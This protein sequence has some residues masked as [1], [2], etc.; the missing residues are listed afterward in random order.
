MSRF[1]VKV[2]DNSNGGDIEL[3]GDFNYLAGTYPPRKNEYI[4][5]KDVEYKVGNIYHKITSYSSTEKLHTITIRIWRPD[6]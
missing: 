1:Q 3:K 5:L 4:N 2:I 6:L